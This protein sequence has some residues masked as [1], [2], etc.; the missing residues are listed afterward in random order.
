MNLKKG[1]R[2]KIEYNKKIFFSIII[3]IVI[4]ILLIFFIYNSDK[5]NFNDK[6][7][8]VKVQTTCCHC[9]MGG[10]EKCVLKTK[11]QYYEK[12]LA[13]CSENLLCPQVYNC[14]ISECYYENGKCIEK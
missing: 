1:E 8:C 7:K 3:L 2:F 6:N 13:N 14:N 11:E 5:N 9:N 4:L 12:Q 10:S